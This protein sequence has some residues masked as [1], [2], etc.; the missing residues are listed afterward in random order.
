MGS[1]LGFFLGFWLGHPMDPGIISKN[2][3][4]RVRDRFCGKS[5]KSGHSGKKSF[6]LL[7]S[8]RFT[9]DSKLQSVLQ[10]NC[11]IWKFH[12]RKTSFSE[13]K[14]VVSYSDTWKNKALTRAENKGNSSLF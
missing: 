9:A 7:E 14:C 12:L 8:S 4:K 2:R 5:D 10:I 6:S 13:I 11:L 1:V 3:G